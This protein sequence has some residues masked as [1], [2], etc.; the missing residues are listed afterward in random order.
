[1][2]Y[3]QTSLNM[4]IPTSQKIYIHTVKPRFS[5]SKGAAKSKCYMEETVSQGTTFSFR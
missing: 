2:F 3:G 1:M 4:F 5:V